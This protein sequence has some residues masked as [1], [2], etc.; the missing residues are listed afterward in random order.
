MNGINCVTIMG[1]LT[2]T[3]ELKT[4]KNGKSYSFFNVAV[5][6]DFIP[7]GGERQADFF[8]C[9]VWDKTAEFLCRNFEKG[10]MIALNGRLQTERKDNKTYTNIVV[11]NVHFCG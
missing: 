6:R 4:S 2:A 9:I 8:D 5:E 1:R 3:P 7:E 10:K 11:D